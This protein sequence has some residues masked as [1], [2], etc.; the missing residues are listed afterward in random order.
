[1]NTEPTKNAMGTSRGRWL[2]P[3]L[4]A[5]TL[6]AISFHAQATDSNKIP[7]VIPPQA[8]FR[9]FSYGEWEAEWWSF[10]FLIPVVD[11]SHP[12]LNGGA[13]AIVNGVL[14]LCPAYYPTVDPPYQVSVIVSPG[15]AIFVPV[16]SQ[17]CS[18]I[19]PPPSYGGNEAEMRACANGIIDQTSGL[20]AVID[21]Q[22]AENLGAYR[23]QSPMFEFGPLPANSIFQYFSADPTGRDEFEGVTSFSVDAGVYLLLAPL[24]VGNHTLH[25]GGT[26]DV[27]G[28]T[29]DTTFNITVVPSK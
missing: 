4:G 5:L 7:R 9:G 13:F 8:D 20:F 29:A 3:F 1:M 6:F 14:F 16:V 26:Y 23:V 25:V 2:A 12:I 18:Q 17:E 22:A 28:F 24:S 11:G 21:G 10:L 15:T 27:F 19:E